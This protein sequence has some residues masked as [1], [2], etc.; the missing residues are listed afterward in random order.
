VHDEG[1]AEIDEMAAEFLVQTKFAHFVGVT[2]VIPLGILVADA[3]P[4]H[5]VGLM[6]FRLIL[7]CFIFAVVPMTEI[8]ETQ[9]AMRIKTGKRYCM[10]LFVLIKTFFGKCLVPFSIFVS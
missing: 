1:W 10:I 2:S 8:F 4:I 7:A 6:Y 9:L 3:I 5:L